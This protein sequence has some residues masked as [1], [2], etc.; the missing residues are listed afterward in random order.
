MNRIVTCLAVGLLFSLVAKPQLV[1]HDNIK[2]DFRATRTKSTD[3]VAIV[4]ATLY[5]PNPDTVYFLSTSCDGIQYDLEFDRQQFDNAPGI[6]CNASWPII[7]KI[8]PMGKLDFVA[9]IK[10]LQPADEIK[11][12][13]DFR[14]TGS[15]FDTPEESI[16]LRYH[17]HRPNNIIWAGTRKF[18]EVSKEQ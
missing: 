6:L 2:F 7:L 13:F 12:G 15:S 18:E 8:P 4:Y 1:K 3:N 11:L 14:E 9:G 16:S 5:N 10:I 17:I